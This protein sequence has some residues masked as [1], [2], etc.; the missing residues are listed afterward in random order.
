MQRR[1]T[2]IINAMITTVIFSVGEK[3]PLYNKPVRA[4]IIHTECGYDKRQV[5]AKTV[6]PVHYP[7]DKQ[8][9]LCYDNGHFKGF[10]TRPAYDA[11]HEGFCKIVK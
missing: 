2:Q 5:Y 3:H 10:K 11:I 8:G 7:E 1:P 9:L 6:K 4:E